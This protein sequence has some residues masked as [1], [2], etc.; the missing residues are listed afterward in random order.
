MFRPSRRD[1]LR[2]LAAA[3]LAATSIDS[4][5]AQAAHRHIIEEQDLSSGG[6][7]S[8]KALNPH[9]YATLD[10]LTDLII[11]TEGTTPGAR[12]AGAAAWIDS[13]AAVNEQLRGIYASGLAWVDRTMTSR[14]AR[15]FVT[16]PEAQQ[17]ALLDQLAYKKNQTPDLAEGVKFFEWARRMT[18]DAFYTS[19]I[20][21]E[22]LG[23]RGNG[24][25]GEFKVPA[26][27]MDYVNKRSPL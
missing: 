27:V 21:T 19:R 5:A 15:D 6:G 16:A 25:L 2:S 8:P 1:L 9:E 12:A 26:E 17:R 22:S 3:A 10:R 7:Y 24:A 13:L 11:P 20:G 23:Y 18:V 4:L 14:G